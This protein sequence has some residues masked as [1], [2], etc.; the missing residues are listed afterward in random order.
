MNMLS[1]IEMTRESKM[2]ELLELARESKLGNISLS[3]LENNL[4]IEMIKEKAWKEL[5][6]GQEIVDGPV[7]LVKR[8]TGN[9]S[10]FFG[11]R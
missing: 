2:S 1:T 8:V 11:N 6:F 5:D 3:E 9:I 4:L 7:K 10:L